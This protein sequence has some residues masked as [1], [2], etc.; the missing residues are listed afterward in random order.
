VRV[1]VGRARGAKFSFFFCVY[2]CG[3]GKGRPSLVW[4]LEGEAK[5]SFFS[6]CIRVGRGRGSQV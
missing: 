1:R 2:T 3:E 4:G 5:F 6:V